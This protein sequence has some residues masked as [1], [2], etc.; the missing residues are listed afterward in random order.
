MIDPVDERQI[1]E[2]LAWQMDV[3]F[4]PLADGVEGLVRD[5]GS[6]IE[7]G[8]LRATTPGAGATGRYLDALPR[9]RKITVRFVISDVLAGML[10]RRGFAERERFDPLAGGWGLVWIRRAR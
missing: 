3:L 7:I 2:L 6:E 5:L 10:E 9:D 8:G 4:V 1:D